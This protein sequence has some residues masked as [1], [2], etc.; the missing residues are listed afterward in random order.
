MNITKN[1]NGGVWI[2]QPVYTQDILE[3]FGMSNAKPVSTPVDTSMKLVKATDDSDE[4]D[5]GLYQ[6]A[7]G[8]LL[9]LSSRTRPDI[10][11]AVS[12]VAQFSTKPNRQ[13]WTAVKRIMRYL[14]GTSNFG[15]LYTKEESKECVGYS[16]ADWAGD[17]DS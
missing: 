12:N 5:Q 7:V 1:Q 2:G 10:T 13:H 8:S 15:L 16:D 11:Y 6:S 4:V 14:R 17:P 3:K 9:Y